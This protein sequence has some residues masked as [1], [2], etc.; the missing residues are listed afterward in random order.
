MAAPPT[1]LHFPV[2]YLHAPPTLYGGIAW[3]CS[4]KA[5]VARDGQ[6]GR[7]WAT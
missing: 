5:A 7:Q 6:V 2:V 1:I 3:I 4:D